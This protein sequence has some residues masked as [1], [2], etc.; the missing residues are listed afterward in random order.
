MSDNKL[1]DLINI[2]KNIQSA[3]L[4]YSGGVDST[5]LLK[6]L[7]ISGIRVLAVTAVSEK[8]PRNDLLTAKRVAA[9][10]RVEHR[11]I[12]T[13]ELSMEEFVSNTPERCFFCK[14]ELFK[15]LSDI[16][17]SEGYM[18]LLDGSNIDDTLDYRPGMRAAK[19]YNVRS[20]LIEADLS[21]KDIRELSRQLGLPTW[22]KPSSPCLSSRFPYSQR[23]TKEALRRVEKAEEFLRGIGFHEVRVRDHENV[24][25]IEVDEE[26][27][28]L[29]LA[30]ESRR[31]IA[32]KLRSLGY[33]FV[34]LDLDG[35]R[36]GSMN[37]TIER[38]SVLDV[39]N[40]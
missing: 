15:K 34:S 33:R 40:G 7:Q 14:N 39:K 18:F 4:A 24:A 21:K 10:L 25:R 37:R 13:D 36:M 17:S 32:E 35:Y 6:V 5:F 1:T 19:R 38:E 8:T 3:V 12:K 9:E 29:V 2:L 23:I 31:L 20:P 30:P 28:N 26:G 22:D 27:I 16:A 11:I